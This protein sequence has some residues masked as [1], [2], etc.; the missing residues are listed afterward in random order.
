[1]TIEL[2]GLRFNAFHGW[3]EEESKT[4]N[5]FEV[6]ASL[7]Y[8]PAGP[9]M[10]LEQTVN[11]VQVYEIVKARMEQR[12]L[13]LETLVEHIASDFQTAFPTLQ[14]L[15]ITIQ[16]LTAPIPNFTGTVGVSYRKEF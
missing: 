8:V 12:Q 6:E 3:H 11:Y 5:E 4:G 9:T 7:S 14:R 15:E 13:L 1:M 2:K 10:I 16:K